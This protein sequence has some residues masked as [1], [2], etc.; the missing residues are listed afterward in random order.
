MK[1]ASYCLLRSQLNP[2]HQ[3]QFQLQR[4]FISAVMTKRFDPWISIFRSY[5]GQ[6]HISCKILVFGA[7]CKKLLKTAPLGKHF[8]MIAYTLRR[9][10]LRSARVLT[11]GFLFLGHMKVNTTY[12][13]KFWCSEL[14]ARSCSKPHHQINISL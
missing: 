8:I 7:V 3:L 4:Q 10:L 6:H 14:S 13:V 12:L 5:E 2:N 1:K 9:K 11:L